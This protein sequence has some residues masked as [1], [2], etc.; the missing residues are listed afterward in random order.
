MSNKIEY[1]AKYSVAPPPS[2]DYYGLVVLQDE[3]ILYLWK[4]SHGPHRA[5]I[6]H[7][8]KFVDFGQNK[9]L[10]DKICHGFGEHL[11]KYVRDIVEGNR[12]TFLTL[13]I[14]LVEKISNYL[15]FRDILNLS[16]LSRVS[17]EIF[18][19]D[20]IWK[21]LYDRDKTVRISLEE[22]ERAKV[23]GWKQLYKIRQMQTSI[24]GQKNSRT[25]SSM[26]SANYVKITNSSLKLTTGASKPAS[27]TSPTITTV[28]KKRS[29][30]L[31][32][33][34]IPLSKTISSTRVGAIAD[35]EKS[36]SQK[37]SVR[38]V[39]SVNAHQKKN[40]QK[41]LVAS[42]T[43]SKK[44]EAKSTAKYGE[45]SDRQQSKAEKYADK[46]DNVISKMQEE[47]SKPRTSKV[48]SSKSSA[49][50]V[51][52]SSSS[53]QNSRK[54]SLR[55][56]TKTKSD[57]VAA[58]NSETFNTD[59][60]DLFPVKN[61]DFELADLIEASLK[62]IRSPRTI[63]DP[64]FSYVQQSD[65]TKYASRTKNVIQS[66]PKVKY[67]KGIRNDVPSSNFSN[68]IIR[69]DGILDKLSE[70]S[71]AFSAS[72]VESLVNNKNSLPS[73]DNKPVRLT[74][75]FLQTQAE[76]RDVLDWKRSDS[77]SSEKRWDLSNFRNKSFSPRKTIDEKFP[78]AKGPLKNISLLN[79]YASNS[80]ESRKDNPRKSVALKNQI[81]SANK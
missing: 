9:I 53:V 13:P 17:Y 48:S 47:T 3:V 24:K 6:E 25:Q 14:S 64:N 44:K 20:S 40:V 62:N 56:G 76:L 22:N 1:L 57:K 38:N 66:I 32:V 78:I 18:N 34:T 36:I 80:L 51:A 73:G 61:N 60:D 79:A 12:N 46:I 11:F 21:I 67:P 59:K 52:T 43:K 71:E 33:V 54:K 55:S 37:K 50:N 41:D 19:N 72:S 65:A 28:M 68:K 15:S 77:A 58:S 49:E 27:K 70:K 16:S 10:H 2:R 42:K 26:K 39:N 30:S 23:Y 31:N 69:G 35:D 63:F 7:R 8:V 29:E 81:C 4:I 45:V 5:P 74:E 75:K